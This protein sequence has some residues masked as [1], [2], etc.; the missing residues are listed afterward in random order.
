MKRPL[1]WAV[2]WLGLFWLWILLAGEW[3]RRAWVAAAVAAVVGASLGEFARARTGWRARVPLRSL[4][5][6]PSVV[7]AV[8]VDFGILMRA[9]LTSL[10]RREIVRGDF[11]A[12]EL[13]RG[14]RDARSAGTRAW[15][16]LAASY[17]PNAYVVDI[18][19]ERRS[20]LLHDLVPRESSEEPA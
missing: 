10:L 9:L 17:S 15:T 13:T 4:S 20:V 5:D 6:V 2:W 18:D 12:R 7:L 16:A 1:A 11:R 14:S 19:R 8:F 3:N